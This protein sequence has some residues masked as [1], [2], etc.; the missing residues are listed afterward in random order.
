MTYTGKNLAFDS[1]VIFST[2]QTDLVVY[3]RLVSLFLLL[4]SKETVLNVRH[5]W[6][7]GMHKQWLSVLLVS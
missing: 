4:A 6:V 5:G 3:L 2:A 1:V 7:A